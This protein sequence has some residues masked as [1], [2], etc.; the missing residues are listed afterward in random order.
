MFMG[1]LYT[2]TRL[3]SDSSSPHKT[4][5][6]DV[7]PA[8]ESVLDECQDFVAPIT[9]IPSLDSVASVAKINGTNSDKCCRGRLQRS[10][11]PYNSTVTPKGSSCSSKIPCRPASLVLKTVFPSQDGSQFS[12]LIFAAAR[13]D[14]QPTTT[15]LTRKSFQPDTKDL[16][17]YAPNSERFLCD[18][19]SKTL[20]KQSLL[21]LL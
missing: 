4:L 9:I 2:L 13:E 15:A 14:N 11:T 10:D 1:N 19:D 16:F 8:P 5:R 6:L 20:L 18:C 12:C 3:E 17:C 21:R 7:S